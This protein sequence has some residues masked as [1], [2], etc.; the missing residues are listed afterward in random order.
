MAPT[1]LLRFGGFELDRANFQLRR[2]RRPVRLERIPLE[3]LLLLVERRRQLVRR[4]DIADSVWGRDIVLDVDNALNTA[5]RKVRRALG[6]KPDQPR[7]VETV[8][9][10]GYR[11][12]GAV[13]SIPRADTERTVG[14]DLAKVRSLLAPS[15]SD[16]TEPTVGKTSAS[17]GLAKGERKQVTALVAHLKGS[18]EWLADRDPEEQRELIDPVLHRVIEA[19]HSYEGTVNQVTEDGILALFGAPLAHEDHA[20]RA[21]YAA[22]R[23]QES[24]RTHLEEVSGPEVARSRLASVWILAR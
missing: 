5:I 14:I 15:T 22:L 16:I 10:M 6:D 11:F 8:A 20:I 21:C 7:Y 12:I 24:V 1:N 19:V 4:R 2:A 13:T 3:V 18:M 9:A 23:I 17:R